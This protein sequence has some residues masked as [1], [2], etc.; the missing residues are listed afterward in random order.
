[1]TSIY[2]RSLLTIGMGCILAIAGILSMLAFESKAV[3]AAV[4]S[5]SN[6]SANTTTPAKYSKYELNFDLSTTY[7]NPFNPDE[8][9]VKA[10]F[11]T[12]GGQTEVVP[13]FYRSN[14]SPKWAVRYSPRSIGS[15]SVYIK[16]TDSNGTGQS[17][18]Y[19][20]TAGNAAADSRGYM[21]VSGN[22]MVDSFNKQITLL[23]SNFAW[24]ATQEI[25][26]AMPVYEESQMNIMRVWLSCWWANYAPEYGPVTTTQAGITMSYDGIGR[27]QLENMARMDTLMQTAEANNIFIM[28]TLNSFGDFYYDW[29]YHAYNTANGGP[30]YWSENNT[31]FWTNPTAIAY[32]KKLLRYVFARW[33][34]STSLGMLEYW[35]E[36]DNR[37]NDYVN[38]P[39]WHQNVDTYWKSWD[40][41]HHPTTSSFAWMD[42]LGSNQ[43]SWEAL[44]TLDVVNLHR[45]DDSIEVVDNWEANLKHALADFGNRPSFFGEYGPP[46]N[47]VPFAPATQRAIHDALW[48]PLFRAGA[49][50]GNLLW[51]ADG[52]PLGNEFNVRDLYKEIYNTFAGFIKPEEYY[53]PSMPFVDYGLQSNSTKVGA[54]KNGDR[55]L[56]WIN[57]STATYNISSP[58]TISGMSFTIP[59]M[60][61]G[62]YS[63]KYYNTVTGA[64]AGTATATAS[65]GNVVLSGIPSFTRDIAVKV[66]RQGSAASDS[67]APT[68]PSRVSA[69]E[70]SDTSI[71]LRWKPANDNIG[72]TR[73]EV[74]RGG[75]L[76]GSTEGRTGFTDSGLSAN[77]AYSYT[78]KAKDA[79]GNSSTASAAFNV[80]TNP[81]DTVAPTAPTNLVSTGKSDTGV[82]LS[83]TAS[84]DN[85]A[86]TGYD[87]Y[88]SSTLIGT[89]NG[90]TT[91][92]TDSGLTANTAYSYSVKARDSKNNV[93][94]SSGSLNVT[95]FSA[96]SNFLLNPGFDTSDGN[97]RPA[98]WTC[99]QVWYCYTDTAVKRSGSS[100]LKVDGSSLAWFGTY[101]NVPA[102]AGQAYTLDGYVNI[103]RNAGTTVSVYLKFLNSDNIQIGEQQLLSLTGTTSGWVN[104]HG[105][106]TAPAGTAYARA[107]IHYATL[108]VTVNADDF[109][110][111]KSSGS[112]T[113]APT[114]PT[115]LS[116]TSKTDTSVTLSWTASTDNVGVAGYEVYRGTTLAGTTNSSTT[117]FTNT[118]LTASTA[119]SFTVKAKDAANNTSSASNSLS[120]TTNAAGG[121]NLLS[122]PGFETDNGSGVP[123]SWTCGQNY[124]SRDTVLKRSG[125]SSLK[126]DNTT[127][128]WFDIHQTV[129]GTAGQSY[130][131]DGYLNITRN[132]G[133]NITVKA[134]FLNSSGTV[135]SDQAI[136]GYNGTTTSGWAR[137][138]GTYT[139][140]AGTVNV[141]I[142]V[143]VVNLNAALQMDDFS[144]SSGSG[145]GDSQAPTAPSSLASPS[146]TA[147]TVSL[148]WSAST[149]NVAVTGYDVYRGST[150]AGSTNGTTT[151]FTDTG[152][153]ANTAYSYT[154]KAKDAAG[155]VSA[156]S[157][158]LAVTTSSANLLLNPGFETDNGSGVPA[159]WTCSQNYCIRDTAVK[160]TADSS[161][162][163]D[164]TTGAW[165]NVSQSVAGT[166]GASYTFD[167]YLNIT[168]NTGTHIVVK[169]EFLNGSS[170]L[171]SDQTVADYNGTL[172]SGWTNVHGTYTAP[173]GTI[174]VRIVTYVYNLNAALYQDDFSITSN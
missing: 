116:L 155:N 119:Y 64:E 10:Y 39:A 79:A 38:K 157:S 152:L 81:L 48:S 63:V 86:V 80:S 4:T 144:I 126:V 173:A 17:S 87:I 106:A 167:G 170:G 83:W 114:A 132:T 40:F 50:G 41:Y 75:T 151:S 158:A 159:S 76:I 149:D 28:L 68:A 56:L 128:A 5:F 133:T 90:A 22:R 165:L 97:G 78:V 134:Q 129:A 21:G 140:P 150:L 47:S 65:G 2:R 145:G 12:P 120:V 69:P 16:V 25:L 100:S 93:S 162:K 29:E 9:D 105:T 130:S 26:D 156:A 54:F 73:Y 166:A 46:A 36:M 13:A 104:A 72:V 174:N 43:T 37:V 168:R 91:V 7:N 110:L 84:T 123:A 125:T 161:L 113:Q 23:G 115:G 44:T 30:S 3:S 124:C 62:T 169:A 67:Q 163:I 58:S 171:I 109:S 135:I 45:Y 57:D 154:V 32:Q 34:Y 20:F 136:A 96:T 8:A 153:T 111:V 107:Y 59:S 142:R 33:G 53:L 66:V 88:R 131:F 49:T 51:V 108:D 55:A 98:N 141:T 101:Q 164:N 95:T 89:V 18:T 82:T 19:T 15:H 121:A 99:E 60:N 103:S 27:Y 61:S 52:D 71:K 92:Y 146:K 14:S 74:Y 138:Q 11:T 112:D 160:R 35:N 127:G 148:T 6:V 122:N 172:T 77:T 70:K 139:A 24:G 137:A 118:G 102:V 31:D 94:S 147:T 85:V 143:S 1:M 117:T 42:A